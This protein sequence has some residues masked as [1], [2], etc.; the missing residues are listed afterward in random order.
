MLFAR[1]RAE[2]F[3]VAGPTR[4][5]KREQHTRNVFVYVV[6]MSRLFLFDLTLNDFVFGTLQPTYGMVRDAD[7][8]LVLLVFTC[9]L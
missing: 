1:Q 5:L 9:L 4:T 7:D 3:E 8:V 2:C 6:D